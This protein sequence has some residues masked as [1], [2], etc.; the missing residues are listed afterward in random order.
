MHVRVF[1]GACALISHGQTSR[2][3]AS[4]LNG[5]YVKQCTVVLPN[6]NFI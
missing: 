4:G 6:L 2:R 3:G 1:V 5:R